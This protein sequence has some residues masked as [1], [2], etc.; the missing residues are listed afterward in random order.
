L[1]IKYYFESAD[2]VILPYR[3]FSAQS[4]PGN[5]ALAFEKPLIVSAVG[6]LSEL[7][8]DKKVIFTAKNSVELASK[9]KLVFSEKGLLKKLSADS[10]KLK[11]QLSW[12]NIS[13]KTI[14][15]YKELL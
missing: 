8:L 2:V 3:D 5:I 1:D 9:I 12:E 4:G 6:G 7:V 15:L 10:K 11:K 14:N 13:K